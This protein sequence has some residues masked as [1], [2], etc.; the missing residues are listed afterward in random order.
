MASRKKKMFRAMRVRRRIKIRANGRLRLSVYRSNKNIYAQIIDDMRGYTLVSAS[1]LDPSLKSFLSR[2]SA[3]ASLVG[4]LVAERAM[5]LGIKD[6][7]FDRGAYI[8]HGRIRA[9][10]EAARTGGLIF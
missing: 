3:A 7:V 10:A 1:T 2:G 4:K 6:V 5:S 8:Y 9:L